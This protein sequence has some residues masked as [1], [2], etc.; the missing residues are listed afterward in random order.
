MKK[1]FVD[2]YINRGDVLIHLNRSDE[3]LE[4]YRKAILHGPTST[5]AFFNV[6]TDALR[7]GIV[8]T[9]YLSLVLSSYSSLSHIF[10][11]LFPLLLMFSHASAS[12]LSSHTSPLPCCPLQLA[13]LHL[14]RGE[15]AEAAKYYKKTLELDPTYKLAMHNLA[16][17]KQE[18]REPAELEEAIRL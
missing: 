3:A 13:T 7:W 12:L 16:V 6:R 17:L 9:C 10:S 5:M 1:D 2:A 11:F 14:Q 4:E 15:K 8:C 18:R